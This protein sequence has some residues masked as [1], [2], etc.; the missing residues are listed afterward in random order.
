MNLNRQLPESVTDETSTEEMCGHVDE[1]IGKSKKITIISVK[2][3][4]I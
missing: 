4:T 2:T 3:N 1:R